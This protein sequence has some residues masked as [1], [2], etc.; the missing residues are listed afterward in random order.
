[1]ESKHISQ[2]YD[3]ALAGIGLRGSTRVRAPTIDHRERLSGPRA[4]NRARPSAIF[5]QKPKSDL[6]QK[7]LATAWRTR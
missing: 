2:A 6:D 4:K 7:Q 5:F 3:A 1:M